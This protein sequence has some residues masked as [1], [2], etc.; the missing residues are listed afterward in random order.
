MPRYFHQKATPLNLAYFSCGILGTLRFS[1]YCCW[2][3]ERRETSGVWRRRC[4]GRKS[5]T[6]HSNV[7]GQ[8]VAGKVYPVPEL[9]KGVHG[10]I[11]GPK[12][13]HFR[14]VRT[15]I[16]ERSR[17][18]AAQKPGSFHFSRSILMIHA[19]WRQGHKKS[20]RSKELFVL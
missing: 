8:K 18:P 2:G 7:F 16:S 15:R 17:K 19:D 6:K 13:G 5:A 14:G 1:C 10:E 4:S 9:A 20:F 12:S 3:T 11:A